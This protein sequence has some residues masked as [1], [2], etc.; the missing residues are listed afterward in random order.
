MKKVA[1]RRSK[2]T[3][4]TSWYHYRSSMQPATR[5]P[6]GTA[7]NISVHLR[8]N[9]D[10]R[11]TLDELS[12]QLGVGKGVIVEQLVRSVRLNEHG[13]PVGWPDVQ[14]ELRVKT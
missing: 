10:V 13:H 5:R 8:V 2:I 1:T 6:R 4:A 11:D 9:S 14:K 7:E 12:R 3:N